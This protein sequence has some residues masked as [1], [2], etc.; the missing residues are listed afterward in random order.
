M[1][2]PIDGLEAFIQIAELGSFNKAGEKLHLTQTAL[3]RRIQRLEAYLGLK[4]LDRTTRVV[5]LS[6][7]GRSFLPEA[8][9]LVDEFER[10]FER[11]RLQSRD[12]MGDVTMAS[13]PS[14]MFGR[15]PSI[16][17][18]Y[19]RR[20]PANRV[21]ILDRSSAL[22]VEAV[23][24]R[25]AEF[26]L[27]VRPAGHP[28]LHTEVLQSDPIVA[29]CRKDHPLA[30]RTSVR[31]A[32]LASFDLITL[33][34]DSGHRT[35]MEAQLRQ[36]GV[37]VRTRFVV[38]YFASAFCLTRAGL[39]VAILVAKEDNPLGGDLVQIPI[40]DPVIDRPLFLVRRQGETL[41]PAARALYDLI[42]RTFLRGRA[43]Q[44]GD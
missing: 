33:G 31:W 23:L 40:V 18:E 4:L 35:L 30:G 21:L 17:A 15:L 7:V 11:L 5:A 28:D 25:Q 3:T 42:R 16:L 32:E 27:H 22:A 10:S 12:S 13:P 36:A 38:E 37:D 2:H 6:S 8:K 29:Y 39:G 14:L 34:G 43:A 9:R 24:R 1:K 19:A 44:S 41:T 20:F 26:G